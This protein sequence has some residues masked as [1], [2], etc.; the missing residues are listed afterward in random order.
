MDAATL[1]VR[2]CLLLINTKKAPM[3]QI[4]EQ[5][6]PGTDARSASFEL[7]RD[8]ALFVGKNIEYYSRK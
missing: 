3:N 1:I 4:N 7:D 5:A 6:V 8:M 2:S